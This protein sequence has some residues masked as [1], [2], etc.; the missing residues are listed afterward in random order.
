MRKTIIYL[1]MLIGTFGLLQATTVS[2]ISLQLLPSV[3]VVNLNVSSNFNVDVVISG[4]DAEIPNEIVSA[5]DLD[6]LYDATIF[7]ATG[8]D[9]GPLLGDPTLFEAQTSAN[10]SVAGV[11]DLA[12]ISFL[13]DSELSSM[14]PGSF[15]LATLSFRALQ[16]GSSFLSFE[17]DPLFG[18][19][20]VGLNATTLAV[21]IS[22]AS[23]TVRPIPLPGALLLLV[24]G[25]LV[26]YGKGRI[27][28]KS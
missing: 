13:F 4:L 16:D 3:Q 1:S 15:T 27:R 12:E 14:Q 5:F 19:N 24:S 2:A 21:D 17:P 10:T 23:V 20:V 25:L 28:T 18:T 6:V 22:G 7:R 26:M 11:V 9:F 8:V